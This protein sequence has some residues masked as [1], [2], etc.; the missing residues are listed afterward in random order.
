MNR[1]KLALNALVKYLAGALLMGA[2]LFLSAGTLHYRGAWLLLGLLMIPM[3]ILGVGLLIFS[4]EL[5]ERRLKSK[6]KREKQSGVVRLSGLSFIVGFVVAGLDHR[7]GW[8]AVPSELI[9]GSSALLLLSYLGYMEV[10]REN[11][12]L[13]RTIEV[14]DNQKVIDT[15]L[16]SVVRHPMYLFTLLLF[17][18]MPLVLGSIWALIPF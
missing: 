5:L 2:P 1:A 12:W 17:L 4:P 9:I 14:S 13:S 15:G 6:E 16:Y 11:V 7:F 8:S 18:S 10:M 3:L